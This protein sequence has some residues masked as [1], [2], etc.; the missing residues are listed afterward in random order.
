ML[1]L[2]LTLVVLFLISIK[3]VKAEMREDVRKS[4]PIGMIFNLYGEALL[5]PSHYK[6][7][8][9]NELWFN[10]NYG[11]EWETADHFGVRSHYPID[12]IAAEMQLNRLLSDEMIQK[13]IEKS[14][15]VYY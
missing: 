6:G 9:T 13:E 4:K 15:V 1:Y 7:V 5:V 12:I 3:A 11:E 10:G 2:T 8:D 14:S